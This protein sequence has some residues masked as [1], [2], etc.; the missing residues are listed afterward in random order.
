MKKQ[1]KKYKL[2]KFC[3]KK[4][5]LIMKLFLLL[6]IIGTFNAISG[7][8]SQ[9]VPVS[10][11]LNNVPLTEAI[12][13]LEKQSNCRFLYVNETIKDKK[14]SISVRNENFFSVLEKLISPEGLKYTI[15]E[16][17][18]IVLSPVIK[19]G[20]TVKGK[21]V[22]INGNPLPG[23]NIIEKG[24]NKGT[25][26]D[27][28]GDY[29]FTVSSP[30]TVLIFSFLGYET[31][32][33]AVNNQEII[34]IVLEELVKSL[35]EV[36]VIGY[37]TTLR[38]DL[39]T[40]VAKVDPDK[41]PKSTASGVNDLLFGKASGVQVRQYSS[42]PGGLINLSIRGRG[43]P[44]IIV[45][46][47]IVPSDALESGVN[48]NEINNVRRGNLANID[49]ND[50]ESI[51]ILK[52]A[53]ASIYG[54]NSSNGVILITTKKGKEGRMNINYNGSYSY[55]KNYPY[56]KP[57]NA[58]EFMTY[59]NIL[60][61]DKYLIDN[62]MQPFG[63]NPPGT[64]IPKF[65][66]QE[67]QNAKTTDWVGYILREGY[68]QNHNLNFNGGS[69]KFKYYFSATYF[70]QKGTV[71]NSDMDKYSG[72][73]DLTFTPNKLININITAIGTRSKF[74]NTVAG[75]Q[76]GGAGGDAYTALQAALAY[77]PFLP[78][79][80]SVTGKFTHWGII[81]NPVAQL[82]IKDK[83][84]NNSLYF[85]T[86]LELNIIPGMLSG[87][88]L[89]GNNYEESLRDFYIPSYVNW[90][91]A[92]RSR[93]SLQQTNRQS[94]TIETYLT[95]NRN[96]KDILKLTAVAGFG[97]YIYDGYSFGLQFFDVLDIFNTTRI[98]GS[99]TNSN[100][101]KYKNKQ[102]SYFVRGNFD[103]WDKYIIMLGWRYDGVDQFFPGNKFSGFPSVSFGWKI[104]NEDFMKSLTFINF[105]KIRGSYGVTGK[106]LP[107]GVAYSLFSSSEDLVIFEDGQ[108]KYIPYLLTSIDVPNLKWEKTIM[109]NIGIDFEIF[110]R[111]L[112]GSIEWFRDDITNMLRWVNTP[113]LSMVPFQ[114]I[115]GGHQRRTGFD[116]TIDASLIRSRNT[117]WNMIFNLSHYSYRWV[118]R[119]KEDD[120]T[121]YLNV[122]DPVLAIYAFET[123]G[124]LQIGEEP[125]AYQP[126]TA[127]L[128]GCPKF[129]D[130]NGDDKLDSADVVIYDQTPK[131][132]LGYS[133]TFRY[134]N[135]DFTIH[136]YGQLGS[137]KQNYSLNWAIAKNFIAGSSGGEQNA[138]IE[139]K[140]A[141]ST[142]NT[143]GTLPGVAYDEYTLGNIGNTVGWGSNVTISKADFVRV[144]NITLGYNINSPKVKKFVNNIRIFVDLQNP[145]I[146]T[147]FK[148]VDPEI[149]TPAVKGGAAPYPMVKNYAIGVNVNF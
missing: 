68:I 41:I 133:N 82:D 137:Y 105:L 22:D 103:I 118:E 88:I 70:D 117:S 94:Q 62:N 116:I 30:N 15:L 20:F 125:P 39:V 63:P 102:R 64:F 57:L 26:T 89:Y 36:V 46:G 134:K 87:K 58:Q 81:G 99:T 65:S 100:S 74:N 122:D 128:P 72:N 95:F 145:F 69:D 108:K 50:V 75:W 148:G 35:D 109:R 143:G 98:D 12:Q 53:S 29:V 31:K 27:E 52:D 51:E 19:Q 84:Y 149:E 76:T 93:G 16:N 127:R 114:P 55:S 7:G 13:E 130:K 24:T 59:Y 80:D 17:N 107:G 142:Q 47:V 97:E 115:N 139:I 45:D 138:T 6:L 123:D 5:I 79:R 113:A 135:F 132:I 33:V 111:K 78:V 14:V 32:E 23:V 34:N 2:K 54:I 8:F 43:T 56:L 96:I 11:N 106:N 60:S 146:I 85:K 141:W 110:N 104:S 66:E 83:S 119:F 73:V 67:I 86:A 92:Y 48:I 144:R 18:L 4:R 44:L 28:N 1:N 112:S 10:L 147:K 120:R 38:K 3:T 124:I 25:I 9:N 40:S 129:V 90:Y 77:P 101:W 131:L 136:L 91:N 42:Q 126:S 121:T 21:V 61:K 71:V 140:D 49:P 37:G